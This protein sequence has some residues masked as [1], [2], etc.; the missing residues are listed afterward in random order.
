[1]IMRT[2]LVCSI[3]CAVLAAGCAIT[4]PPDGSRIQRLPQSATGGAASLTEAQR[5]KLDQQNAQILAE[6]QAAREREEQAAHAAWSYGGP[7]LLIAH[8]WYWTGSRWTW[9]PRWHWGLSIYG[10]WGR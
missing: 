5:L 1:M 4:P 7:H 3:G 9:R 6:Q 2:L 8:G 10:P